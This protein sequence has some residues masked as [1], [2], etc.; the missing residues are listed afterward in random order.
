MSKP[1]WVVKHTFSSIKRWFRSGK[2]RYKGL[3]RVH[4]QHLM[5]PMAHNL[6]RTPGI[7]MRCP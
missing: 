1:K 3:A 2:A 6:Y 5:E 4:A 7:I